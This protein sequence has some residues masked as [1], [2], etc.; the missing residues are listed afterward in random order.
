ME[1]VN[2]NILLSPTKQ[3][4]VLKEDFGVILKK[5]EDVNDYQTKLI[6]DHKLINNYEKDNIGVAEFYKDGKLLGKV[7]LSIKEDIKK[8]RFFDLYKEILKSIFIY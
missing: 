3:S 8:N 1:K 2:K 6:I 5:D 7:N 4:I